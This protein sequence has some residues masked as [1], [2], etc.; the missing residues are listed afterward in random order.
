MANEGVKFNTMLVTDLAFQFS[1]LLNEKKNPNIISNQSKS[2][3]TVKSKNKS[4]SAV[5]IFIK[6]GSRENVLK[7]TKRRYLKAD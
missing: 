4:Q 3:S 2:S 1:N 6:Q 5:P 7:S